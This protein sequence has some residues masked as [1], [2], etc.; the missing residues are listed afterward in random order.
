MPKRDKRKAHQVRM[1]QV[2][3]AFKINEDYKG[4]LV[5]D[6]KMKSFDHGGALMVIEAS[7]ENRTCSVKVTIYDT[8]KEKTVVIF[9]RDVGHFISVFEL[10]T[11][12]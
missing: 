8:V 3:T 7:A 10:M 4:K 12:D 1:Q 11:N 5:T 2:L 9:V 6:P